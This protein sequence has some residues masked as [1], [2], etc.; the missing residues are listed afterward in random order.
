MTT[1]T[2]TVA[3]LAQLYAEIN[4]DR[5]DMDALIQYVYE[6]L[7]SYYE[8]MT[9]HELREHIQEMGDED[10]LKDSWETGLFYNKIVT[11]GFVST[12]FFV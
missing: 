7:P 6:D 1:M 11:K 12:P 2:D 5:M 8:G 9:L 10:I 4:V 3:E